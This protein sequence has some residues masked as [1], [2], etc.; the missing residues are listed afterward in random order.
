VTNTI[1]IDDT[2]E[3]GVLCDKG[4]V[5]VLPTWCGLR[6][7]KYDLCQGLLLWLDD[8]ASSTTSMVEFVQKKRH[9]IFPMANVELPLEEK[10]GVCD[11]G[12]DWI[13]SHL[14]QLVTTTMFSR[15]GQVVYVS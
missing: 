5:V 8:L 10:R 7:S 15:C 6:N 11:F 3:K 4:S 12:N 1:L 13:L 14:G 9:G 2:P